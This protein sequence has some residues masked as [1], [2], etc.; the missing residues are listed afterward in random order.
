LGKMPKKLTESFKLRRGELISAK[1][2]AEPVGSNTAG[3]IAELDDQLH[4]RIARTRL[5]EHHQPKRASTLA[6]AADDWLA[7]SSNKGDTIT[8]MRTAT[9]RVIRYFGPDADL[10]QI[11]DIEAEAWRAWMLKDAGLSRATANRDVGYARQLGAWAVRHRRIDANPFAQLR[12]GSQSN[13]DRQAFIDLATVGRLIESIAGPE[14]RLLI[15]LYL[16]S[17][18]SGCRAK[19]SACDGPMWTRRTSG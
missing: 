13:A 18:G 16:G 9:H 15:V 8:R 6:H 1:Q 4:D 7:G 11:G 17:P 10:R 19:R 5:I 3:W 12:G 14:W 2:S